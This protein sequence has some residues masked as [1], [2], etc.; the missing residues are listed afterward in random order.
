MGIEL[1]KKIRNGLYTQSELKLSSHPLPIP[2]VL[3]TP[4]PSAPTTTTTTYRTVPIHS[5]SSPEPL[6]AP[7]RLRLPNLCAYL[8]L[9]F[10]CNETTSPPD[11]SCPK[12]AFLHAL[13]LP[14]PPPPISLP[15]WDGDC[16]SV[17]LEFGE[18]TG[19]REGG[20]RDWSR[21]PA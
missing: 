13:R 15:I 8:P 2:Q 7:S 3:P 6:L 9:S 1:F 12:S 4:F 16:K 5:P 19:E 17:R 18:R 10:S 20:G 21:G 14:G 11:S